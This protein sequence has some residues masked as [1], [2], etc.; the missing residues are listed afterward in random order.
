MELWTGLVCVWRL[1]CEWAVK[2]SEVPP[3]GR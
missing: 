2:N 1:A 3:P